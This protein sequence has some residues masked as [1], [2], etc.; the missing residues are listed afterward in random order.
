MRNQL[1][2]GNAPAP[3][4]VAT[5]EHGEHV[6]RRFYAALRVLKMYP[7]GNTRSTRSLDELQLAADKLLEMDGELEI[8]VA[9]EFLF[10]NATRLRLG[11]DNYA[12]LSHVIHTFSRCRIGTVRVFQNADRRQWLVF[13]AALL[14]VAEDANGDLGL[15]LLQHR[16]KTVHSIAIEEAFDGEHVSSD[17]QVQKAIAKGT[18]QRSVSVTKDLVSSIRMGRAANLRK[19]QR[20]VQNIVDQVLN[21]ETSMVGLT[22][23]RDYDDY[24]FTHSVN[25]CIFS[26]SIGK[27]L[28]L[29]KNQLYDLGMAALLHDVGKSRVPLEV[30]NKSGSLTDD[31]WVIMKAHPWLGVLALFSL[32]GVNEIPYR[33]MI[34][35]HEHHMKI[36]LT[37][38]P[39]TQLER[40]LTMFSKLVTVAD[41]YDAA[42]SKRVYKSGSNSP[43]KIIQEMIEQQARVGV[44]PVFVKALINLLGVYPVG[45]CVIL[46]T[47]EVGIVHAANPDQT[48]S[49]RPVVR[50]IINED[51]EGINPAPLVD[52]SEELSP[53][54]HERSIIK[55]VDPGRYHITPSDFFV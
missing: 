42:T 51:G 34:V 21:N 41:I 48:K 10:V 4:D 13:I 37:G 45:T 2:T 31:E 43:D 28:D 35:A 7:A 3:S 20:A 39:K 22:T 55:V 9:G 24:T 27:R 6:L 25:V 14:A 50:L 36:D 29:T 53:G 15:D 49:S 18:Y 1:Q 5:R 17:A 11:M 32:Q 44:D 23:L 52:L 46:D 47:H 26:L 30:L 40:K 33:A 16:L 54:V 8:R 12:S 19:V 38:Y